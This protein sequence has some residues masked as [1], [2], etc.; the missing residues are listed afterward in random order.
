MSPFNLGLEV[1]YH[2]GDVAEDSSKTVIALPP[3]EGTI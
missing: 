3:T 2:D 1:P